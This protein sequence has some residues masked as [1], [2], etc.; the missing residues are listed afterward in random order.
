[1]ARKSTAPA[2]PSVQNFSTKEE[3]TA[4]LQTLENSTTEAANQSAQKMETSVTINGKPVRCTVTPPANPGRK[5][6]RLFYVEE[7]R[8][9]LSTI[10]SVLLTA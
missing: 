4:Y 6:Y 1:M 10:P 3:L 9:A 2:D 5:P 7:K 8:K